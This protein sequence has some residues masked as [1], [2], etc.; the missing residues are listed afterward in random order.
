MPIK[1]S[2]P[3]KKEARIAQEVP[4]VNYWNFALDACEPCMKELEEENKV[5]KE[6]LK[7]IFM[8]VHFR[9]KVMGIEE[10]SSFISQWVSNPN[11]DI[12]HK[13][14]QKKLAIAIHEAQTKQGGV[15]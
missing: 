5:L 3:N 15:K 7:F 11:I 12:G 8:D 2:W 6:T 10:I 9:P 4:C 1:S 13:G 14:D